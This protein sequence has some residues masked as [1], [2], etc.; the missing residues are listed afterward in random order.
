[1][2]NIKTDLLEL[3]TNLR[4]KMAEEGHETQ[5]Q[6]QQQDQ[7]VSLKLMQMTMK[8]VEV[9]RQEEDEEE[10]KAKEA[11]AKGTKPPGQQGAN[12]DGYC[13]SGLESDNDLDLLVE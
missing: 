9:Q 7:E 4:N 8:N 13:S 12:E 6:E 11:K 10:K 3:E 5:T 2:N 1:M